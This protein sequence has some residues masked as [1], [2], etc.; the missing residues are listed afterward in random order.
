M[1]R[2]L[3]IANRE[4][5]EV[6]EALKTF[7]PWLAERA[8]IIAEPDA[9]SQDALQFKPGAEPERVIILGGDGTLLCQARRLADVEAPLIGIN[10]GKLGFLAEFSLDDLQTYWQEVSGPDVQVSRRLLVDVKLYAADG[11]APSFQSLAMNDCVITAGKP[12][13]MI[14]LELKI[15]PRRHR[16]GG[17]L[18]SGDGVIVATPSGSTAYNASAGGPLIAPD[19]EAMIITPICPQSLS[20]RAIVVDGADEID[21]TLRDANAGTTLVIDGQVTHPLAA[22]DRIRFAS[23]PK[24][25]SI[26]KNPALGYWKRLAKKMHWA[27]PPGSNGN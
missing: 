24:R 15:N 12:F 4:K 5:P 7:R 10:F 17:T 1:R 26:V 22:G 6:V 2:V 18:F 13:R 8:E 23:Y 20:F 27:V 19:V 14:D 25:I 3:L 21:I 11:E 9:C 16:S